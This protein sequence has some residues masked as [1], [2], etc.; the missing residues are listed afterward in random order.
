MNYSFNLDDKRR[1]IERFGELF[2]TETHKVLDNLISKWKISDLQL[3]DALSSNLVFKGTSKIYDS[4]IIKFCRLEDEFYSEV[5]ALKSLNTTSLC[6]LYD[7]DFE[8]K[9]ILEEAVIPGIQLASEKEIEKRLDVFCDLY[10]QLHLNNFKPLEHPK[11]MSQGFKYKSYEDWIFKI[12]EYMKMQDEWQ[13]ITHHMVRAK[14]LYMALAKEYQGQTLLHGD[15][16]YYNILKAEH[17]YKII[18]PKGVIGNPIFDIPRYMLNEYWD[19][20]NR[21]NAD[22]IVEKVINTLSSKLNMPRALLSKLLYIEG[23][24]AVCWCIEDG[25]D[26]L[27]KDNYINDLDKIS[28]YLTY[29]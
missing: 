5:N 14:K 13:E 28:K 18:D 19:V 9:V 23:T 1:I 25:A 26:I 15:F 7:V 21:S 27:E 20:K 17:G 16:H 12:T 2:Y 8:N 10:N 3:I 4:V 22:L 6:K 24:M 11:L 29:N